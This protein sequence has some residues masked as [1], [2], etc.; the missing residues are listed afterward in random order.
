MGGKLKKTGI[1][2]L[3]AVMSAAIFMYPDA[4]AAGASRGL[5]LCGTVIIPSLLPFLVLSGTFMRSSLCDTAG[6]W[7][8]RPTGWL[9][10]LP[11][12]CGA[13]ILLS[14]VG[15]YP[16]GA[17]AVA[18]L[19]EREQIDQKTAARMMHFCVNAGPAFAVSAVGAGMLRDVRVGFLLLAAHLLAA[20][21]IGACEG[22]LSPVPNTKPPTVRAAQPLAAAFTAAVN[23]A[24]LSI[25]YMCGFVIFFAV[26][27]SLADGSG[28]S[29]AMER[30]C[31]IGALL[32][33]V[34][35]VSCGCIEVA[36]GTPS[37]FLLGFFLGFG[38]L[39]VQCQV[40]AL[41]Q[42]HPA[43]LRRFFL[44]RLI[45]GLLGGGLSAL[46]YRVIPL[47]LQTLHPGA[48]QLQLFTASPM[49]S[50]AL[51]L[52]CVAFLLNS[53]KKIAKCR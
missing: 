53:E 19:L 34:L 16:A 49:A 7:L 5:S 30:W 11:G 32:P 39:S 23:S 9:F 41:L 6:R 21:V 10:R 20:I 51:L 47:P 50:L 17:A 33:G 45:H 25:L 2:A 1:G 42:Q 14:M 8:A 24:T 27:V 22:W 44:F 52:M 3:L 13:P 18:S 15:G 35:E 28:V 40:R 31:G 37:M 29:A 12:A 4:A 48:A 43:A 26:I 36:G 38:G 46:L